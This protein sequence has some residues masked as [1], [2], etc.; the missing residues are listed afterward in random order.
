[1]LQNNYRYQ[2]IDIEADLQHVGNENET[3]DQAGKAR[4]QCPASS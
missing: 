3:G 1:M 2:F 4:D